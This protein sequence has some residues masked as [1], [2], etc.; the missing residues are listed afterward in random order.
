MQRRE[1][2]AKVHTPK[3][4]QKGWNHR[5]RHEETRCHNPGRKTQEKDSLRNGRVNSKN[6][7]HARSGKSEK[8]NA[9]EK[10]PPQSPEESLE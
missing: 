8:Q 9:Q 5:N 4:P 3:T 2:Q 10:E 6:E 1:D 7:E